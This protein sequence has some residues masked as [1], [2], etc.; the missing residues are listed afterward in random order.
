MAEN[1]TFNVT[2]PQVQLRAVSGVQV[3]VL[4]FETI[5]PTSN[6]PQPSGAYIH[7]TMTSPDISTF[8][9]AAMAAKEQMEKSSAPSRR[10]ELASLI[11]GLQSSRAWC[12]SHD[13]L[14]HRMRPQRCSSLHCSMPPAIR[15]DRVLRADHHHKRQ[16]GHRTRRAPIPHR[17]IPR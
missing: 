5:A 8:L 15:Q 11:G 9:A 6:G 10:I 13:A 7:L 3:L 2:N 4:R 16:P 12:L 17:A 1:Q 14:R